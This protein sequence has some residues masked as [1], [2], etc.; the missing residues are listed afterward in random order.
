MKRLLQRLG[1]NLCLIYGSPNIAHSL[2]NDTVDIPWAC[3]TENVSFRIGT[4]ELIWQPCLRKLHGSDLVIVEQANSLL[5]N[6]VLLAGNLFHFRRL[7]F[8]GHGQNFQGKSCKSISEV[9]KAKASKTVHWWFAYN[10]LSARVVNALGFPA[11]RITSVQNAIDTNSLVEGSKAI[12]PA[13]LHQLRESLQIA[14]ENVCVF[15]THE[16]QDHYDTSIFVFKNGVENI[17]YI[18]GLHPEDQQVHRND[19]YTG[20]AYTEMQPH[21]TQ[22]FGDIQVTTIAAND[23]GLGYLVEVDGLTIY[24][25]GDHAGWR[26]GQRDGFTH[27]INYLA[28]RD[29]NIDFAFLNVTGCHVQDTVALEESVVYTLEKLHPKVWFPTHGLNREYVYP[30]F[31]DKVAAHGVTSRAVCPENR[32]DC[33]VYRGGR[34]M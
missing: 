30:P 2:K 9:L 27:E 29:D 20:P 24:H 32:G 26:E 13:N 1:I 6:Y 16:H 3:K 22:A 34:I 11:D 5:L 14:G 28:E 18:Y 25:A 7:A 33:F 31:A 19:G 17:T 10:D 12:Q 15:V 23:A 4:S 8:W 21:T